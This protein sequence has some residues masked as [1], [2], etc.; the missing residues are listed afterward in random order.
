M[1]DRRR[2]VLVTD[3]Q[4]TVG[5]QQYRLCDLKSARLGSR[6]AG[7][8]HVAERWLKAASLLAFAGL[9]ASRTLI[10]AEAYAEGVFQLSLLAL[11]ASLVAIMLLTLRE[12]QL[13]LVLLQRT[14]GASDEVL[15]CR[16]REVAQEL[17][18]AVREALGDHRG[19]RGANNRGSYPL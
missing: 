19:A 12:R 16:D 13:Y 3:R 14:D 15:C 6:R 18:S 8:A 5:A 7:A 4:V 2:G 1:M 10:G 9:F 11:L 17:V